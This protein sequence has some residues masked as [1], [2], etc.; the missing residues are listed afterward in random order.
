MIIFLGETLPAVSPDKVLSE[1]VI[2]STVYPSLTCSSQQNKNKKYVLV[3]RGIF[4]V[5]L[6][7][8]CCTRMQG[9][10]RSRAAL[11]GT[12]IEVG[13]LKNETFKMRSLD[14]DDND[15]IQKF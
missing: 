13:S 6:A 7:S 14:R 5:N 8:K 4:A 15:V 3:A 11:G 10:H 12:V 2:R 1:K 9:G